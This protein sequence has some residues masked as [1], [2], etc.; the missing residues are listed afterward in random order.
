MAKTT[1]TP[2]QLEAEIVKLQSLSKEFPDFPVVI[3]RS[4]YDLW[5]EETF[6]VTFKQ[7]GEDKNVTVYC[8]DHFGGE[9][10]GD[11]R[12]Y[13]VLRV[14]YGDDIRYFEK[15]GEYNSWE[16]SE[17]DGGFYEVVPEEVT[18]KQ[19]SVKK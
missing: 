6:P 12:M 13:T 15:N 11:H 7:V 9:E 14:G 3:D 19:W 18:V 16:S 5:D 10:G 8:E 4:Y 2:E 17:W 1:F